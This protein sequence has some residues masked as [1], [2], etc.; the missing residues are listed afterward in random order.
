[1]FAPGSSSFSQEFGVNVSLYGAPGASPAGG[2]YVAVDPVYQM[3]VP[4]L[5]QTISGLTIGQ[6]VDVQFWYAG[7]QQVG[8]SGATTE[9]WQVSLGGETHSTP[10]L[11]DASNGFTGWQFA[12]LSFLPTAASEVLSFT[13][14]GGPSVGDPPFALLDGVAVVPE[15]ATWAMFLIGFGG[16]GLMMR[17]S[18]RKQAGEIA[19]A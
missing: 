11:N 5:S 9:G 13:A 6:A 3:G 12:S 1:L 2:N 17:R 7:A 18:R 8:Y 10:T 16:I 19:S 15:P 14:F 4:D